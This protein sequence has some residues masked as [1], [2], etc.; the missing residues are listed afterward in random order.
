M[1]Y[2][3]WKALQQLSYLANPTWPLA[4]NDDAC[5]LIQSKGVAMGGDISLG[6]NFDTV[7]CLSISDFLFQHKSSSILSL[8]T[9][10]QTLK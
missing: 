4:N 2:S 5:I 9:F 7:Y 6:V 8:K 3:E 1:V 10:N